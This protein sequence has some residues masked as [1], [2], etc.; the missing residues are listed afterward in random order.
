MHAFFS[1]LNADFIHL[2]TDI[3]AKSALNTAHNYQI[4]GP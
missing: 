3:Y 2:G 4:P 1:R